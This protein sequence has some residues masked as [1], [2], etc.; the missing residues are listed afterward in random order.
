MR[1][2]TPGPPVEAGSAKQGTSA[3]LSRLDSPVLVAFRVTLVLLRPRRAAVKTQKSD[4]N[5]AVVRP[6][7]LPASPLSSPIFD[8]G[9]QTPTKSRRAA[10]DRHSRESDGL[11]A[12]QEL[13]PTRMS[14]APQDRTAQPPRP[15]SLPSQGPTQISRGLLAESR[16]ENVADSRAHPRLPRSKTSGPPRAWSPCVSTPVPPTPYPPWLDQRLPSERS[17]DGGWVRGRIR[18]RVARK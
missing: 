17:A 7:R 10:T 14:R 12:L 2:D 18:C 15:R 1:H 5:L 9:E 13:L 11:F 16:V 3:L 4:R 8:S 6:S